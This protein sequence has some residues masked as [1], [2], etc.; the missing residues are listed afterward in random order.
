MYDKWDVRFLELAKHISSWSKD[1]SRKI[2]AV[3]VKNRQV[4]ATGYNGF[5]AGISDDEERYDNRELK[6]SLVVH[7]EMN[8][9]YNASKNG[10]SLSGST[11][12]VYGLPV[13]SE[14]A[15][16]IIQTGVE[17]VVIHA[18]NYTEERWINSFKKT[19]EL[20]S[21]AGIICD[22]IEL[23]ESVADADR[24]SRN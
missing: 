16:G 14:C 1:P 3:A 7:A 20:F 15:K 10:M 11:M 19:I 18:H 5:P 4:M 8:C 6:Y 13:C 23:S 21:E 17:R 12:F 24:Y 9:I 22:A 2:G